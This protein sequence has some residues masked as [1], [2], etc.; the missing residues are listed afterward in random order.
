LDILKDIGIH[1]KYGYPIP[2]EYNRHKIDKNLFA[3]HA[4]G[5]KV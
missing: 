5:Q 2:P 1:L 4:V 3:L